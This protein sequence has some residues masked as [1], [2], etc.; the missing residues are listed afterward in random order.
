MKTYD[1]G[2][3]MMVALMMEICGYDDDNFYLLSGQRD[4]R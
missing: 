1:Q 4:G 2:K 3:E